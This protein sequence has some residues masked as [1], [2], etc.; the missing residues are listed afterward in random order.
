MFWNKRQQSMAETNMIGATPNCPFCSTGIAEFQDGWRCNVC[1]ASGGFAR[2][3]ALLVQEQPTKTHPSAP[4]LASSG[5]ESVIQKSEARSE[6]GAVESSAEVARL[7]SSASIR[8]EGRK[9]LAAL[10]DEIH[11]TWKRVLPEDARLPCGS[12]EEFFEP[13][14]QFGVA[15]YDAYAR[16]SLQTSPS[17]NDYLHS[18][19]FDL[20]TLVC[21]QIVRYRAR[22]I[23]TLQDALEAAERGDLTDQ[24][25]VRM[26]ES[27]R[28]F[29]HPRHGELN[30]RVTR[31][32]IEALY[33]EP[34][35]FDKL[36]DRV[37]KA[38]SRRTPHWWAAHAEHEEARASDLDAKNDEGADRPGIVEALDVNRLGKKDDTELAQQRQKV[39]ADWNAVYARHR[40]HSPEAGRQEE[41]LRDAKEYVATGLTQAVDDLLLPS[42]PSESEIEAA[43]DRIRDRLVLKAWEDFRPG[44]P[45][46]SACKLDFREF[47][48][49]VWTEGYPSVGDPSLQETTTD[50]VEDHVTLMQAEA[51]GLRITE[52]AAAAV[53]GAVE[54]KTEGETRAATAH[55]PSSVEESAAPG[56]PGGLPTKTWAKVQAINANCIAKLRSGTARHKAICVALQECYDLLIEEHIVKDKNPPESVFVDLPAR[57]LTLA[58]DVGWLDASIL[59]ESRPEQL[60]PGDSPRKY[61]VEPAYRSWMSELLESRV[62]YW[63]ARVNAE[64]FGIELP[65]PEFV[66]MNLPATTPEGLLLQVHEELKARNAP[67]QFSEPALRSILVAAG[68][69]PSEITPERMIRLMQEHVGDP[70]IPLELV[71]ESV[72]PGES[73]A[74]EA[75]IHVQLVPTRAEWLS[76][77]LRE[78]NWNKHDVGRHNG[79]DH[80]TVQKI[81]DGLPVRQDV[82]GKLAQALSLVSAS[83]KLPSI[84]LLDI[85]RN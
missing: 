69:A 24:W 61:M 78:R 20:K 71:P 1:G 29:D 65:R 16:E 56:N 66:T 17:G 47:K 59:D 73:V 41:F 62:E 10:L 30:A 83:K 49:A 5:A 21:D 81:L 80:K 7:L 18:L 33:E 45:N 34:G 9:A 76:D 15:L 11:K 67:R 79:P 3:R 12:C 22:P 40:R 14:V 27:W 32:L 68:A 13:F 63:R 31:D 28:Q 85:P 48:K 37:H 64:P 44:H 36:F 46:S 75:E 82:L 52:A 53:T 42:H 2:S 74:N 58:V 6:Q 39:A 43:V 60:A 19:N 35:R 55:S 57:L 38:I 51:K 8:T 23:R 84:N 50:A 4:A 54:L 25:T 77:R 26:G 70:T 72:R